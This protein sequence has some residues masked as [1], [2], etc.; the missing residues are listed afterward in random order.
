MMCFLG[1]PA[2]ITPRPTCGAIGDL[3]VEW[4]RA[5]IQA[6]HARLID[7]LHLQIA[8]NS[9][10]AGKASVGCELSFD[11]ETISFEFAHFT[12]VSLENF[13]PAGRAARVAAAGM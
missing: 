5:R 4:A 8:L 2:K 6:T 9:D 11:G 1:I 7:N 13:N 12:W 10:L 3:F